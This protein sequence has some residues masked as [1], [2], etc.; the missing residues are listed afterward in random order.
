MNQKCYSLNML[1]AV[2]FIPSCHKSHARNELWTSCCSRVIIL[3]NSS[4]F[5]ITHG[6]EEYVSFAEA[7]LSD[8][9]RERACQLTPLME[10]GRGGQGSGTSSCPTDERREGGKGYIS[11]CHQWKEGGGED[12]STSPTFC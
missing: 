12:M 11:Q 6:Q 4:F 10:E 2:S 9:R 8:G 5:Q 7:S 3:R 1:A